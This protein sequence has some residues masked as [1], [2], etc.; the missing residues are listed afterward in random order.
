LDGIRR[1]GRAAAD[2]ESPMRSA[3][4]APLGTLLAGAGLALAQGPSAPVS[5][6]PAAPPVALHTADKSETSSSAA[7]ALPLVKPGDKLPVVT[8]HEAA[9]CGPG[10][11][12]PA[13]FQNGP[14]DG[15]VDSERDF[16]FWVGGEYLLWWAKHSPIGVPLLTTGPTGSFG[17]LG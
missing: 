16:D 10:G 14:F 15:D 5:V 12:P 6:A 2:Q 4:L 7:P 8:G 13:P 1:R 9:E 3:L 17:I 11:M